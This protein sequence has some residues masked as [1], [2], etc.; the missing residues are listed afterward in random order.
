MDAYDLLI[1]DDAIEVYKKSRG[2]SRRQFRQLFD[3]LS[4]HPVKEV[5][6]LEIT[7]L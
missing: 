4:D 3:L 1:H 2:E 7:K 6:I 5:K